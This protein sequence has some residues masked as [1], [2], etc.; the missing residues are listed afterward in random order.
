MQA[1]LSTLISRHLR[2]SFG[3]FHPHDEMFY[4]DSPSRYPKWSEQE[5]SASQ[6]NE[7]LSLGVW[8]CIL[9]YRME[10]P[11]VFQDR[12]P[13][14]YHIL[15]RIHLYQHYTNMS[16]PTSLSLTDLITSEAEESHA[17]YYQFPVDFANDSVVAKCTFASSDG[18]R[19]RGYWKD[20]GLYIIRVKSTN[21]RDSS[22]RNVSRVVSVTP[23]SDGT[24]RA[25]AEVG[26]LQLRR[27]VERVEAGFSGK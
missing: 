27:F 13:I 12:T 9:R 14:S 20:H 11:S 3:S 21:G 19:R 4:G 2:E 17:D 22:G 1:Y 23:D 26:Q 6:R 10:I 8:S 15:H 7:S 16:Q 5:G 18:T 24:R 25:R